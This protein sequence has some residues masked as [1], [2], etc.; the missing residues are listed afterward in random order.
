MYF[1]YA[2]TK[3]LYFTTNSFQEILT[4]C[5]KKKNAI[6]HSYLRGV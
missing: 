5:K 6:K 3:Y 4:A 2:L 1:L